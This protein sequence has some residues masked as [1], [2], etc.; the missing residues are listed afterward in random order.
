VL[1]QEV[2]VTVLLA[3]EA[4]LEGFGEISLQLTGP[5]GQVLWKKK[6]GIS[7]IPKHGKELW[8]GIIAA[9]G[10]S[11]PHRFTVRLIKDGCIVGSADGH[12]HP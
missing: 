4:K 10:S 3:N 5:T 12:S 9:S 1:R 8:E 6:R 2:P 7:K 11:G